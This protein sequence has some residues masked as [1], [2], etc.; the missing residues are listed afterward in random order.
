MLAILIIWSWLE[1]FFLKIHILCDLHVEFGNFDPPDVGADVVVLAGDV[2][3]KTR[4]LQ[5]IFEQK[6]EIPVLYVL[7]NHEFYR[8]KFPGLIDKLKMDAQGTHVHVLENDAIEIGGYWFYG[9]TL[10]SDMDL[11]GNEHVSSIV[12]AETMNDYRL[13][14]LSKTYRRL[15]PS[16]TKAWHARSVRKLREFLV[17]RDPSRTIVV[18]HHAPSIQS[19]VDR[20]R[21]DPVSAA[22]ASNLEDFILDHQP[23]LWIHGHTHESFDYEIGKTRVVC[24]PRGYASIE[25]NKKFRPDYTIVL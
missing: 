25:E 19:I 7:G 23:R 17:K 11:L 15:S 6:F 14:R 13:I 20:Y 18:T 2:H 16:D 22:F 1:V 3:V 9:C 21:A 8:E 24:N 10:W 12:A 5:W 4:G